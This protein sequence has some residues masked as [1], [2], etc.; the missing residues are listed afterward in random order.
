MCRLTGPQWPWSGSGQDVTVVSSPP[1]SAS[2]PPASV[3]TRPQA[4]S[5]LCRAALGA[6]LQVE[7]Q[8]ASGLGPR[9]SPQP[10][11]GRKAGHGHCWASAYRGAP[12]C[13]GVGCG[14]VGSRRA[15]G[16]SASGTRGAGVR[17]F[18]RQA[19]SQLVFLLG[20]RYGAG[21]VC[22]A[23]CQP[24]RGCLEPRTAPAASHKPVSLG[25]KEGGKRKKPKHREESKKKKST[26][27]PL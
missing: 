25:F 20:L 6:W 2:P 27:G 22:R 18:H 24:G 8:K 13:F 23:V 12:G 17:G 15:G 16:H 26:K 11:A 21:G 19:L 10:R 7:L 1:Y 9:P 3:W 5:R 14:A 4:L